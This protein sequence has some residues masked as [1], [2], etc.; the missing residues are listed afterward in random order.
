M[1]PALR[2]TPDGF[3]FAG[4]AEAPWLRHFALILMINASQTIAPRRGARKLMPAP[5]EVQGAESPCFQHSVTNLPVCHYAGAFLKFNKVFSSTRPQA[6]YV[7]HYLPTS[8][9]GSSLLKKYPTIRSSLI[10]QRTVQEALASCT[11]RP[12]LSGSGRSVR[13]MKL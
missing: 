1:L 10:V 7:R 6:S 12:K 3:R 9:M 5:H 4:A 2:E 11:R 8:M 13:V